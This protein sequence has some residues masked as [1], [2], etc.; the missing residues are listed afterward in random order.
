MKNNLLNEKMKLV[1]SS[2]EVSEIRAF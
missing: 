2:D 1:L